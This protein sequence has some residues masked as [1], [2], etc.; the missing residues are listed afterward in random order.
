MAAKPPPPLQYNGKLS[1]DRGPVL[2][3]LLADCEPGPEPRAP[4]CAIPSAPD[5]SNIASSAIPIAC[6]LSRAQHTLHIYREDCPI[7]TMVAMP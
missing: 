6:A 2:V 3:L 7:V 1:R 5:G 4:A